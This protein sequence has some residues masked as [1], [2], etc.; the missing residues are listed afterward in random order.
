[1]NL[2]T[3]AELCSFL[4]TRS[5]DADAEQ[6]LSAI[7]ERWE[8]S[9][10][11]DAEL[12]LA[13]HYEHAANKQF[14][15]HLAYEEYCHRS[16]GGERVD[17][18]AFLSRFP[19][20]KSSLR[21]ALQTIDLLEHN[22]ELVGA[23]EELPPPPP[24]WPQI[25]ETFLHYELVREL[26]RG[27]FSR[28]FLARETTL[29]R[30][31][32]ALKLS[33][34]A[35]EAETLGRLNH[36]NIVPVYS[37]RRDAATGLTAVCMPFLGR[38]TLHD[39]LDAAFAQPGVPQRADVFLQALRQAALPDV[40]LRN[41]ATAPA[42]HAAEPYVDVVVRLTAA[43]ADALGFAHERGILHRDLKPSNVL[44][45]AQGEPVL[46]DFNLSA[47]DRRITELIG[48]TVIYLS[49]EQLRALEDKTPESIR[50][51]DARAEIFSLAVM[52]YE[53]LSGLHP[54]GPQQWERDPEELAKALWRRQ[55]RGPRPLLRANPALEPALARTIDQCLA[56]A[57]DQRLRSAAELAAKLRQYLRPAARRRRW[58]TRHWGRVSCLLV[59]AGATLGAGVYHWAS[60]EPA[61]VRHQRL[62][63]EAYSE[64]RF[65]DAIQILGEA[66]NN[67]PH[68][69][70]LR[71][72][73]GRAYQR[74]GDFQAALDDYR[75]TEKHLAHLTDPAE[76][77]Q[78]KACM[79]YCYQ[80]LDLPVDLAILCYEQSINKNVAS[81]AIY[82]NLGFCYLR[83][84]GNWAKAEE[85]LTKALRKAPRLQAAHHNLA[86]L[87]LMRA[88]QDPQF[89]PR[90]G[91]KHLGHALETEPISVELYDLAARLHALHSRRDLTHAVTALEFLKEMSNRGCKPNG[92]A[93]DPTFEPLRGDPEFQ[94]LIRRSL[95]STLNEST[96]RVVD[97]LTDE[98]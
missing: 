69:A 56:F 53:L 46:L 30:R 47:D 45:T 18:E 60:R 87:D 92:L 64:G 24:R 19:Q 31:L 36:P 82:N 11:R 86:V 93:T 5:L 85:N 7:K 12:E 38:T 42:F 14:V 39:V 66:L 80:K 35:G 15:I 40:E 96:H 20:Y 3:M 74:S 6:L 91:L 51:L 81:A 72:A 62:G 61:A 29:G 63:L 77:G 2:Q 41:P 52:A 88:R 22:S 16:E 37:V 75:D 90:Q 55:R 70:R 57:P 83:T 59:V 84:P 10:V 34:L 67:D 33:Q 28:V 65:A 97:P 9:G 27:A 71:F 68:N 13:N 32:V 4:D 8:A 21:L 78:L 25:G 76:V 26:G 95:P 89:Y 49:P 1:M 17:H 58:L 43:L 94:R 54:F 23:V 79:G 98:L 50:Q 48:G 44:L 73:R